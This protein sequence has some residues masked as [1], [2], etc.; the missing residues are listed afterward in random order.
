MF[1][2]L[3]ESGEPMTKDDAR[4]DED[5]FVTERVW[6]RFTAGVC[7]DL[8]QEFQGVTFFDWVPTYGPPTEDGE[9]QTVGQHQ[10]QV[11]VSGIPAWQRCLVEQ[12]FTTLI[13]TFA[14]LT[15]RPPETIRNQVIP[16]EVEVYDQ[17][18]GTAWALANGLDP[19]VAS[20]IFET[21]LIQVREAKK[22]SA[23]ASLEA[24]EELERSVKPPSAESSDS[25]P[26]TPGPDGSTSGSEPLAPLAVP[27]DSDASLVTSGT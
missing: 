9:L 5:P 14:L 11:T 27:L 21:S 6:I 16:S 15:G 3:D 18:I 24:L 7:A 8:E 4:E 23:A 22:N 2:R 10:Q 20:R 17:A 19:Q 12:T 26:G 1:Y 25:T 13:R